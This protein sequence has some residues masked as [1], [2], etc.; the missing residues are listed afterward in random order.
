M[1]VISY[2]LL[3]ESRR[4][5]K[6][7]LL[8]RKQ[9]EG[10][11][12]ND[13]KLN[14]TAELDLSMSSS[15]EESGSMHHRPI[16][17]QADADAD[18]NADENDHDD[19]SLQYSQFLGDLCVMDDVDV[20][21]S[22]TFDT[23]MSVSEVEVEFEVEHEHDNVA[24]AVAASA[25]AS[26]TTN[27]TLPSVTSPELV[28]QVSC[29]ED[30][31]NHLQALLF[32]P[33]KSKLH[34]LGIDHGD[35]SF[36]NSFSNELVEL[37]ESEE[38]L[39]REL[40]QYFVP[41]ALSPEEEEEED[42]DDDDFG[43]DMQS[44]SLAVKTIDCSQEQEQ[45]QPI[46]TTDSDS[47]ANMSEAS[48]PG[49]TQDSDSDGGIV[50]DCNDQAAEEEQEDEQDYKYSVCG[51]TH[52]SSPLPI[53]TAAA[54]A[55]A[56]ATVSESLES[57]HTDTCAIALSPCQE[58][59]LVPPCQKQ[60][61][62]PPPCQ[63]ELSSPPC[64]EEEREE[65]LAPP[66]C[67]EQELS[68]PRH[69]EQVLPPFQSEQVSLHRHEEALSSVCQTEEL[70]PPCQSEQASSPCQEPESSTS[71]CQEPESSTSV[72]QEQE[73]SPLVSQTQAHELAPSCQAKHE[74]SEPEAILQSS[75]TAA[76]CQG[77][78]MDTDKCFQSD[79]SSLE[80]DALSCFLLQE[81]Q[82]YLQTIS[83]LAPLD[84]GSI[85]TRVLVLGGWDWET[86]SDY[87]DSDEEAE[88][89]AGS[90]DTDLASPVPPKRGAVSGS[91][92]L[93]MLPRGGLADDSDSFL[94]QPA[95][96]SEE[97]NSPDTAVAP[98][99]V[100][101]RV[102]VLGSGEWEMLPKG[103]FPVDSD[104]SSD[105]STD[106]TEEARSRDTALAPPVSATRVSVLGGGEWE[107]L[108]KG[109]LADDSDSSSDGLADETEEARS[110]DTG[111]T[112]SSAESIL[113]GSADEKLPPSKSRDGYSNGAPVIH[114]NDQ[115]KGGH[116]RSAACL[117]IAF[118]TIMI[119]SK[120]FGCVFDAT[121][122]SEAQVSDEIEIEIAMTLT[123]S[124]QSPSEWSF[125]SDP[126][127]PAPLDGSEFPMGL[128]V[129]QV[130]TAEPSSRVLAIIASSVSVW[131]FSQTH[132][133]VSPS[134]ESSALAIIP[135]TNVF[136]LGTPI[137]RS[138]PTESHI[139]NDWH[140][141][142]D[143]TP[144]EQCHIHT[145]YGERNSLSRVQDA[146]NMTHTTKTTTVISLPPSVWLL[147][148]H[149]FDM[150]DLLAPLPVCNAGTGATSPT[151]LTV[152]RN[153]PW[154][155]HDILDITYNGSTYNASIR[156]SK[157]QEESSSSSKLLTP[158]GI[159]APNHELAS[160]PS[161]PSE[162][163]SIFQ[164]VLDWN[165]KGYS[166]GSLV[167]QSALVLTGTW[168][169]GDRLVTLHENLAPNVEEAAASS[170][171]ATPNERPSIFQRFMQVQKQR[172][173]DVLDWNDRRNPRGLLVTQAARVLT[174]MRSYGDRLVLLH[175]NLAPNVEEA[176]ASSLSTTPNERP[177]I[178]QRLTQVQKQRYQDVLDWN[179]R[180]N[181]R[182]LLVTQAARLLTCVRSYGDRLVI[183]YGSLAPN[184]DEADAGAGAASSLST[185]PKERPSIFQ[186]VMQAYKQRYQDVLDWKDKGYS[187][188]SLVT[189]TALVLT[190]TW[191]Y[192]DRLVT[193]HENLAPN[194]EEAAASSLS[195]TPNERPSIFQRVM[196]V[197]K[198]QYQDV[199]DWNDR[200]NPRG[201]LVTQAARLLT[202]MR[203][204]RDR[205]VTLHRSRAPNED[206]AA[207][208]SSLSTTPNERPSILQ[209]LMQVQ[210]QRYQDVLDW[211]D[212]HNPRGL[213][214]TQA[215]RVLTCMRSYR[216]RL[217]LLHEN[218][219]PN[220][221]EA[222][223][224]GLS[225]T[226]NE[227][228]SILQRL[229]Q[230][231]KQRY[232]DVLDWNDRRNIRGLLLTQAA[233][234]LTCVRSYGDRLVTLHR[235]RAPNDE[236]AATSASSLSTTPNERPTILQRLM[237][238]QKQR[239]QDV[240]DWND[241]RNP[242]GL[243][244]T[245]AALVLT[246]TWSYGDRLLALHGS[247]ALKE[248]EA[249]TA[250]SSSTTPNERPTIFQ[251]Q[252][253]QCVV[254]GID[255]TGNSRGQLFH[256]ATLLL[257][258]TCLY[259]DLFAPNH[260]SP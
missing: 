183:L 131:S 230:A 82:E 81:Y 72:S 178:F 14:V 144:N 204:Y 245:Q 149:A 209:R 251:Q 61:L 91:W 68:L 219:A 233:R 28:A 70:S 148:D 161:A 138:T 152:F 37:A 3:K 237:Q 154:N 6:K 44:Q 71:P 36:S 18:D 35:D 202:G 7:M 239:Y 87:D 53:D 200:R 252:Q 49:P 196:P 201:L 179:D 208:A 21:P 228:P 198:Q 94:D 80:S 88:K 225:T 59:E 11:D 140:A 182:G 165:D 54:A 229:M 187:R 119:L 160:S 92:A 143:D 67:Q 89:E 75:T 95:D 244:L 114:K 166:R 195:T 123:S 39:R 240:L 63:E 55:A 199:L 47:V 32:N 10:K 134:P 163:P 101:T 79:E 113:V 105:Q 197:Q 126:V 151:Q 203:S 242:R 220:V 213:L 189:Q 124:D 234:L 191:S 99:V 155:V 142:A 86:E 40:D 107:M 214:L 248:E 30:Q 120:V 15:M 97:T 156:S 137:S 177:S 210:K 250:S 159:F 9:K 192:G 171:S 150:G 132:S 108:P 258:D 16:H 128:D 50:Q 167:T 121:L 93:V 193:L 135:P 243:L 78:E 254:D 85:T 157:P 23:S 5:L 34:G 27:K 238:V 235:S 153:N 98:P 125:P 90:L 249:T 184:E 221:E 133:T 241:R 205:L 175:E 74:Q 129:L 260:K 103:D 170:L 172:Y 1:T 38:S 158:S 73:S 162:R 223:A 2:R 24:V 174:G 168:S 112:G 64:P 65:G 118:I 111:V 83:E 226:P 42:D 19:D 13:D 206:K 62:L 222:D 102:S 255:D 180:R 185:T 106:E 17:A 109:D 232:Q 146:W 211:N 4:K 253:E 12:D 76:T 45:E 194:V 96:E 20:D 256:E 33:N 145:K 224:S 141:D 169:Y 69:T 60:G 22:L 116:S 58:Q 29:L 190:G 217:V 52:D 77:L 127:S 207:A 227:R 117:V 43:S 104:S 136:M 236:E 46:P 188:G 216:D 259:T 26:A 247:L 25:S 173:Q 31:V 122:V 115:Q 257:T 8:R 84:T 57:T 212:R 51:G 181:P 218:L 246:G 66:P 100:V 147:N 186:R 176:D 41:P 110:L 231:Q 56:A 48:L 164:R 130:S 139:T 215:A